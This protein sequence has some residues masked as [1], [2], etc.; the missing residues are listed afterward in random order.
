MLTVDQVVYRVEMKHANSRFK[1]ETNGSE[2]AWICVLAQEKS[3]CMNITRIF[4]EHEENAFQAQL[5]H[6]VPLLLSAGTLTSIIQA[7][8]Y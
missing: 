5:D 8:S 1:E 3:L 2:S 7:I 6:S 4:I